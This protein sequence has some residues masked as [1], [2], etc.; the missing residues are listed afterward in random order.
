M[1]SFAGVDTLWKLLDAV[2]ALMVVPHDHKSALSLLLAAKVVPF[3]LFQV[4]NGLA[5]LV[6]GGA[7]PPVATVVLAAA[8]LQLRVSVPASGHDSN[9]AT[10]EQHGQPSC[11]IDECALPATLIGS[12]VLPLSE[13]LP[14]AVPPD[15]A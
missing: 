13:S 6:A 14:G 9:V 3:G 5:K 15:A 12:A 2:S 11:T 7:R 4:L 10:A 8:M 1:V